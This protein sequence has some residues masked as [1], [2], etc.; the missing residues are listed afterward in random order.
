[1]SAEPA[2]R[3]FTPIVHVIAH[4]KSHHQLLIKL[5]SMSRA[6]GPR[7][8]ETVD[9]T[10]P[11]WRLRERAQSSDFL[12][13]LAF[14]LVL[15]AL[16]LAVFLAAGLALVALGLAAFLAAGFFVFAAAL[17]LVFLANRVLL[18]RP[19]FMHA[20]CGLK[21]TTRVCLDRTHSWLRTVWC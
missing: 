17:L 11:R 9:R 15:A 13:A 1:M 6:P 19:I 3:P 21:A 5:G 2:P 10:T 7:V 18:H 14:G 4:H 20:D 8:L 12:F 16:G